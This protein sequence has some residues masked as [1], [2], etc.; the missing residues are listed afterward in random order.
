VKVPATVTAVSYPASE[1]PAFAGVWAE[2]AAASPYSSFFTS[3]EWTGAWLSVYA[4]SLNVSIVIFQQADQ[5]VGICLLTRRT[6]KRGPVAVKRIY[7]NTAGEDEEDEACIEFNN[8]LCLDGF[9]NAVSRALAVFVDSAEWDEF[10]VPGASPGPV[11]DALGEVLTGTHPQVSRLTSPYVDL[12]AVRTA[13]A[14]DYEKSLGSR[15]RKNYRQSHRK[16][17]EQYGEVALDRAGTAAEALAM[18]QELADLHQRSWVARGK[19]GVFAS[20]R[21]YAFHRTLAETVCP[22][23]GVQFWKLRAGDTAIGLIYGFVHKNRV[24]FYQSGLQYSENSRLQPGLVTLVQ[25]VQDCVVAG[26]DEF[27]FLAGDAQYKQLLS[28]GERDLV[29][30]VFQRS[31]LKMQTLQF[32]SRSR[33]S[34]QTLTQT[35]A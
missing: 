29:W 28:S 9:E 19:P 33:R 26:Y 2:L 7:L 15:T 21:F 35:T 8:L 10:A 31:S 20:A 25:V 27:H 5:P 1:W 18:L 4:S 3:A 14:G 24:Y 34:L 30:M 23:H 17:T 11:V 32:L 12:E 6:E 13:H 22:Q 16:Y